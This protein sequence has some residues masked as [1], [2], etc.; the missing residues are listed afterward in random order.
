MRVVASSKIVI[1]FWFQK[2]DLNGDGVVSMEEFLEACTTDET[3]YQSVNAFTNCSVWIFK[4]K[5]LENISREQWLGVTVGFRFI[6]DTVNGWK[7]GLDLAFISEY[8]PVK[9]PG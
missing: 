9:I 6:A 8:I 1:I 5:H 2:L 7:R 4:M 3:I